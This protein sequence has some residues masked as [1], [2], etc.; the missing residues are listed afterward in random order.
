MAAILDTSGQFYYPSR[1]AYGTQGT[2]T[3]TGRTHY[4]F[5][6]DHPSPKYCDMTWYSNLPDNPPKESDVKRVAKAIL[7]ARIENLRL[8]REQMK[9][10]S[11][12]THPLRPQI[13]K[14][15][16]IPNIK[17]TGTRKTITGARNFRAHKNKF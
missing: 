5:W 4:G 13:I 15:R 9:F 8:A 6:P 10:L 3:F 14:S 12:H 11:I 17:K 1:S 16:P 2:L 7:A